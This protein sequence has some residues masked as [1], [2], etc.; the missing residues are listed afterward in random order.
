MS[1][2]KS[3]KNKDQLLLDGYRYPRTNKFKAIWHC[4]KDNYAGL[5]RFDR[6]EYV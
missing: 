3:S 1:I 2:V 5:L 4:C 6:I